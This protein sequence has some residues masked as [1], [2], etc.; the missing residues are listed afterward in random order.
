MKVK[1]IPF[2][3]VKESLLNTPEAIRGTRKQ[4]KSWHWSK[5]CTRCVKRLG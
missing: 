4:I 5:C 1:G 3:Q 2:N